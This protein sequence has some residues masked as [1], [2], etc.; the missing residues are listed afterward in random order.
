MRVIDEF[1]GWQKLENELFEDYFIKKSMILMIKLNFRRRIKENLFCFLVDTICAQLAIVFYQRFSFINTI[2]CS[3]QSLTARV[4]LS[5]IKSIIIFDE[6]I[7]LVRRSN[8]KELT[9]QAD[10]NGFFRK[11]VISTAIIIQISFWISFPG[12][13]LQPQFEHICKRPS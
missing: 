8:C 10:M 6:S 11:S 12:A 1:C 9:E 4:F 3:P 13:S 2:E 7:G 5:W